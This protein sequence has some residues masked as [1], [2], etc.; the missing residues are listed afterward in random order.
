MLVIEDLAHLVS[1]VGVEDSGAGEEVDVG[2]EIR[3]VRER[4]VRE[5]K[6][7]SVNH[8]NHVSHVSE[9]TRDHANHVSEETMDHVNHASAEMRDSANAGDRPSRDARDVAPIAGTTLV[10]KNLEETAEI[11]PEK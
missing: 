3:N 9:E 7:D 5:R 1:D 6:E 10:A 4:N 11:I 2:T 8:V